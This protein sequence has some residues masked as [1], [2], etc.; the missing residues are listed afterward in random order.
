M[1]Q[2]A[3]TKM[4][5]LTPNRAKNVE[6]CMLRLSD[7][8]QN[9]SLWLN[10][11]R[12]KILVLIPIYIGFGYGNCVTKT[13]TQRVSFISTRVGLRLKN[14]KNENLLYNDIFK[15]SLICTLLDTNTRRN[16]GVDR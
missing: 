12:G 3:N 6:Y 4:H 8:C 11:T 10:K 1:L 15:Y 16:L 14:I 5:R 9:I 2:K 13:V 7:V